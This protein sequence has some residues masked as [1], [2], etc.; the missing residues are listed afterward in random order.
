[1]SSAIAGSDV[2][3]LLHVKLDFRRARAARIMLRA[4]DAFDAAKPSDRSAVAERFK[5]EYGALIPRGLDVKS[6]FRKARKARLAE[7]EARRSGADVG[8]ARAAA[9]LGSQLVNRATAR[10]LAANREF[11]EYWWSLVTKFNRKN[12]PAY[13]ALLTVLAKGDPIPGF[14]TWRQIWAAENGGV[15][16]PDWMK[17]PW[18]PI[19]G[20]APKGWSWRNVQTINPPPEVLTAV[21]KGTGAAYMEYMPTVHQTRAG[22]ESCECVEFDDVWLEQ[23]V[24]YAGNRHAQRVVGLVGYDV[25]TACFFG[26][27]F[28]PRTENDDGT[29]ETIRQTYMRWEIAHLLCDVGVS[30]RRLEVDCEWGSASV[31][32]ELEADI[33]DVVGDRFEVVINRGGRH[34]KPLSDGDWGGVGK[35]N[36]RGK[37]HV[38]GGHALAKNM[39]ACLPGSVGGGRGAQPEWATGMDMEDEALRRC[40]RALV[41]QEREAG[42]LAQLH[43]PYMDWSD[44]AEKAY[45]VYDAINHRRRHKLEGWA[46]S[47]FM[48]PMWRRD[49][50]DAWQPMSELAKIMKLMGDGDARRLLDRIEGDP[51]LTTK[52][53]MSPAEAWDAR[54]K[55]RVRLGDWAAPRLLG[56]NLAQKCKVSDRLELSYKDD[57]SRASVSIYGLLDN[58][59]FLERGAE[60]LVWV[61]P[62]NSGVAYVCDLATRFLGTAQVIVPVRRGDMA[63]LQHQLRVVRAAEADMR[64]RLAPIAAARQRERLRDRRHNIAV[65]ASS[66]GFEDPVC[67][68]AERDAADLVLSGQQGGARRPAEPPASD[69]DL[70]PPEPVPAGAPGISDFL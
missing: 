13:N 66:G 20:T 54:A 25:A 30:A 29:R 67:G 55:E 35:G 56:L 28:R 57:I 50:H 4:V 41:P 46:E 6:L 48:V 15:P 45:M 33:R 38:E 26:M 65:L 23:K 51:E 10:G 14:G 27:L 37:P 7:D 16:P 5:A 52:R 62:L 47:G 22:L 36:P 68:E 42:V 12:A 19:T 60:Y 9:I 59:S 8:L 69:R 32:R 43:S 53:Q 70:L 61:N 17:C 3:K 11:V 40:V 21:R 34:S 31:S 1:M 63:G 39:L 58:G 49:P 18:G 24:N 64:R 44:F 2:A